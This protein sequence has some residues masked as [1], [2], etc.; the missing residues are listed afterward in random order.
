MELGFKIKTCQQKMSSQNVNLTSKNNH[1]LVVLTS[2]DLLS[3]TK[4]N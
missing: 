1:S 2:Y 4:Q 3:L